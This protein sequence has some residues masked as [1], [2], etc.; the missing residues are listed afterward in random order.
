MEFGDGLGGDHWRIL[1]WFSTFV[2]YNRWL[3]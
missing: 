3:H 2:R 1:E